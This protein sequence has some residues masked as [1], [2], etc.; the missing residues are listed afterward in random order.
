MPFRHYS[1]VLHKQK[2]P[3]KSLGVAPVAVFVHWLELLLLLTARCVHPN[4]VLV[5]SSTEA[6]SKALVKGSQ[7][8]HQMRTNVA[9][10]QWFGSLQD[11]GL[12]VACWSETSRNIFLSTSE[13]LL[14]LQCQASLPIM[15]TLKHASRHATF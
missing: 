2:R 10:S 7:P 4:H 1:V 3:K 8:G 15:A 13:K 12:S 9:N 5:H 14:Q 6:V 11:R